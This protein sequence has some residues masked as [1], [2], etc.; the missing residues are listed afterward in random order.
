MNMNTRSFIVP[1]LL[2]ALLLGFVMPGAQRVVAQNP[3]NG[4]IAIVVA[5]GFSERD[6]SLSLLRRVFSGVAT[7]F[8][9]ERLVPF[10]YAPEAPARRTLDLTVLGMQPDEVGAYWIDRR[11]RGDGLPP[12]TVPTPLIMKSVVTKLR[13]AI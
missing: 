2:C 4:A 7:D 10:N 11:I 8:G 13:G 1:L 5:P 6:I 9:G 3:W 12:R